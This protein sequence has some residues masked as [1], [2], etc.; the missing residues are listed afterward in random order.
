MVLHRSYLQQMAICRAAHPSDLDP[1]HPRT[2]RRMHRCRP[3]ARGP[4][5]ASDGGNLSPST[6]QGEDRSWRPHLPVLPKL[7]RIS[8]QEAEWCPRNSDPEETESVADSDSVNYD[9]RKLH[10]LNVYFPI[11]VYG[12]KEPLGGLLVRVLR[13]WMVLNAT[14]AKGETGAG[15]GDAVKLACLEVDQLGMDS[16]GDGELVGVVREVRLLRNRDW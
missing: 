9:S 1:S 15:A 6:V 3:Q 5:F 8:I 2:Q 16:S 14:A 4:R 10:P 7:E 11:K 12:G 13:R